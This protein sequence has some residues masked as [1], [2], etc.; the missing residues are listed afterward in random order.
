[1]GRLKTTCPTDH[2]LALTLPEQGVEGPCKDAGRKPRIN[3]EQVREVIERVLHSTP[4]N[5][6]HWSTRTMA[7]ATGLPRPSGRAR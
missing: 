5:G 2:A 6:T 7:V 4:V 3:G 1:M